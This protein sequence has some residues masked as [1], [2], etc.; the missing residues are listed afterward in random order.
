[1][2]VVVEGVIPSECTVITGPPLSFHRLARIAK[3]AVRLETEDV[4]VSYQ[5]SLLINE[6]SLLIRPLN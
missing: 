4:E 6:D 3:E 2:R 1:M 5:C